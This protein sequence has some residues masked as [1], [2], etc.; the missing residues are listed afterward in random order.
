MR[1]RL[2]ALIM[3]L[4]V[5]APVAAAADESPEIVS[6]ADKCPVSEGGYRYFA[7]SFEYRIRVYLD[8]CPWYHGE[9]AVVRGSLVRTDPVMGPAPHEMTVYCEPGAPPAEGESHNH[10]GSAHQQEEHRSPDDCVLSIIVSHPP[11]EHARYEGEL[12]YPSGQGER[13]ET[14]ALDC[15]N[16]SDIGGCDPPGSPP[17]IKP[18]PPPV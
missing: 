1:R 3:V 17:N 16:I 2:P 10:A 5:L 18:E 8:G 15:T 9:T 7:N 12:H 4:A 11:V 13:H 6:I 14:L